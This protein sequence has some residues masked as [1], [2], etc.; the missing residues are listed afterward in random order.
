MKS[1]K[2]SLKQRIAHG[3]K[4]V[5]NHRIQLAGTMVVAAAF[6]GATAAH[7]QNTGSIFGSVQDKTG[8]SVPKATVTVVDTEHG[9]TR[10]AT[11]N[12]SG[13]FS[14]PQ[15]PVGSYILTVAAPLFETAVITDI[16]V[17][18]EGNVKEVVKLQTGATSDVVTV[19]DTSGSAIDAKSAT[20]GTLLDQ[21][22]IEDLPIDGH[23]IVAL[24]ALLPGVVDVNAPAT[25][26]GDTSGPTYSASGSRSTQNLMLFDGLMWNNLFYNTGINYPTPNAL[27]E[28]S[29]LL[30]NYKAQY[31]RNAG[32]VFNVITKR[33]TNKLHGSV[34][35]YLQNQL[36]N[37]SDYISHVNPK[38]NINQFGFTVGGPV[39]IPHVFDG[40]DRLFFYGAF[41]DLIGRLQT[42]ASALTPGLAERGLNPDGTPRPCTAAGPFAGLT[43]A[44][45]ATDVNFGKFTNPISVAGTSGNQASPND[46]MNMLNSASLQ[47]GGPATS[48]CI[49]LLNQAAIYAQNKPY[50]GGKAQPTY[51]PFAEVP[52]ACLNPV[53]LK[54]LNTSVPVPDASGFAV[55]RSPAPTGDKNALLRFDYNLNARNAFDARYNYVHSTK[56]APLGVN[57]AS[58][59]VA[60]Y[61]IV[62]QQAHSNFG[63]VGW[64]WIISPS[65]LSQMR[66]GYK[67][68]E[69]TQ[70]PLDNRTLADFG[71]AFV[72]PGIPTL[73]AFTFSNQFNLGN[74]IQGYQDHINEN[75]EVAEAISYTK[76]N[77]S[78]QGGFNFLRLQYLN[79]QD[80]AGQLA[81]STTFTG[82]SLADGLFGLVNSVQAQNRLIQ[83]GIQHNVFTYLQDDWRA[84]AKL[85][86]NLG[87]RY[88]V[89][90]QWF[91]PH[92]QS[93]T[94]TPGIQSTVFPTAIG[95][96]GFPGDRG[97]LPSLVPTDFNGV[98]PRVGF[99]YD[100][101][102]AGRLLIR[103]G[104]GIF[105]D[106]VNANVIGVGEPYH[107]LLNQ[108]L[109]PGGA[110]NPLAQ[111]DQDTGGT[112]VVPGAFD[113]KHPVF[114]APYSIFFPDKNFRTPYVMA[115][116]FGFQYHIPHAGVL[117]ANYVGK[118]ARKLTIP[119]DLN[120]AIY[121]CS[122][123]YYQLDPSKYC[124]FDLTT[125]PTGRAT[126]NATSTK[127]RVRYATFNYGG[128]GIVDIKSAANSSYNALQ[129][130]Y[131]QRGGKLL[132]IN[133]SY[134]Y[135][136]A[137]DIQT[138]GLTVSN[139]VPNVFDLKSDRGPSDSNATHNFSLGWSLRFPKYTGSYAPVRAALNNWV[140]TGTYKALTGKPFSVT[141]NNDSA[142]SGE[143]MQR[144]AL[145]PGA[146]PLLPKNRHRI[147]KV[148]EYFNRDAFTYPTVGTYSSLGR[149]SF[150][151][152]AYIMTNMTV[153]RDFPLK[154]VR[155]GMRVNFRAEAFNVFNTPNLANPFAQ[156]SCSTTSTNGGSCPSAGGTY[157][158]IVKPGPPQPAFANVRST[159]GN[160]SNTSTNGRK[161]QFALTLFY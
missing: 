70:N 129:V 73:P 111:L 33:G 52:T 4:S 53:I 123:G 125:N 37:A 1:I 5:R 138:N 68:Y 14:V 17:D 58:Q 38:D 30:N 120:P 29:I 114:K 76:G 42:T 6:C 147:D 144:A 113:P 124:K 49:G 154:S 102:G 143:P 47:A 41:Q 128:Q 66:V 19:E 54:V 157:P 97:V 26:T 21:K 50:F 140:Y 151:G 158:I 13:E 142:L 16:K 43:C 81:F 27:Q 131:S 78:L 106:A 92:G 9:V 79:R 64:Q 83:G 109:P 32:S 55:T 51:L 110:S 149:N 80:Y 141:I 133:S 60:T 134:T 101:T 7:G 105:F 74:A 89:P 90:F 56:N 3:F 39:L 65:M 95:G 150:I 28:V 10:S 115:V 121:D 107:F 160:N 137:I 63:N 20:L 159:F 152:P 91:E 146:N 82:N 35:D 25:F 96:L 156:F 161:F 94:F 145:V 8:A 69:S 86:L 103:G 2:S 100:T 93:A 12:G 44:S 126:S 108:T 45:F 104:F 15:L 153:G 117:E 77:H 59:G 130:Q 72:E 139:A 112:L 57:G 11:T 148:N 87:V 118:F 23:N 46:T 22:L 122:G 36:F 31:G 132:S 34:W 119:V 61:A 116:N 84:T 155:E 24:A 75:V 67:R 99:A 40:R 48:P 62:D 85:T 135:S 127:E 88:E 136:R 18:A 71:G 98:A